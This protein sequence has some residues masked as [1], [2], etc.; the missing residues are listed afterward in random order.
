YGA[1]NGEELASPLKWQ[2]L[3]QTQVRVKRLFP[4]AI[5]PGSPARRPI[6]ARLNS[7]CSYYSLE[8]DKI[9]AFVAVHRRRDR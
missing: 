2:C 5:P 8:L 3:L 1:Q 4:I 9:G 6:R 7:A